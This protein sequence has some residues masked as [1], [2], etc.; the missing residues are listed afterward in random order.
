MNLVRLHLHH[1]YAPEGQSEV[2]QWFT[3]R[4]GGSQGTFT[5]SRRA[6][7]SRT[8]TLGAARSVRRL[9]LRYGSPLQQGPAAKRGVHPFTHEPGSSYAVFA[10]GQIV[11]LC[12]AGPSCQK[13]PSIVLMR[14]NWPCRQH[15]TLLNDRSAGPAG[16]CGSST[17]TTSKRNRRAA[18]AANVPR[19]IRDCV[20]SPGA[21]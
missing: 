15:Y 6:P 7:K 17:R 12:G 19:G 16:C 14:S 11:G 21:A 4:E 18:C 3:L 13:F 1:R 5:S 10:V 8:V 2:D 9:R 20:A